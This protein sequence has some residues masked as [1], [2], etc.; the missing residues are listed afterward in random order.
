[1]PPTWARSSSWPKRSPAAVELLGVVPE[2]KKEEEDDV[3]DGLAVEFMKRRL[4]MCSARKPLL[5]TIVEEPILQAR[6][7]RY[8]GSKTERVM[9]APGVGE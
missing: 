4:P 7:L 1:M 2:P 3:G 5:E 9:Y 6:E 8:W